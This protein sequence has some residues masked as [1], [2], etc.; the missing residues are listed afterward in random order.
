MF[1][2]LLV[3]H[4]IIAAALVGVILMQRSEGGGLGMG[5]SPSGLMSARGAAD[6]LTRATTILAILFVGLSIALATVATIRRGPTEL[7]TSLA[8][9]P[10]VDTTAPIEAAPVG[11]AVAP[12][13]G[14]APVV[15]APSDSPVPL[16][17]PATPVST[18]AP[19]AKVVQEAPKP[20]VKPKPLAPKPVVQTQPSASIPPVTAPAPKPAET[21][22]VVPPGL[23]PE[24][25]GN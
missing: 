3:V 22:V 17:V 18:K 24:P 12:V 21:P 15:P 9:K 19:A 5:G 10:A 6:F 1:Q 13:D 7:D 8:R 14:N 20:I 16:A 23:I 2:F 4:I 11:N 25:K